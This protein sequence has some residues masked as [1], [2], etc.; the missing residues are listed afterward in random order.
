MPQRHRAFSYSVRGRCQFQYA[1]DEADSFIR[2]SRAPV[3]GASV[4]KLKSQPVRMVHIV[5]AIE[6]AAP[7]S[8]G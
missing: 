1:P 5:A 6:A 7:A 3:D 4:H 8:R 2:A